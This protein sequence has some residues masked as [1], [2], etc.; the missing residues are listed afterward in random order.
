MNGAGSVGRSR[1]ECGEGAAAARGSF[2]RAP[3]RRAAGEAGSGQIVRVAVLVLVA[4]AVVV[5][6]LAAA[7]AGLVLVAMLLLVRVAVAVL[8][9]FPRDGGAERGEVLLEEGEVRRV[10]QVR[11]RLDELDELLELLDFG[12]LHRLRGCRVPSKG[13]HFDDV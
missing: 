4:A 2:V 8:L 11:L 1:Q 13:Y 9:L 12:G 5:I 3:W 7:T 10:Q 6:V